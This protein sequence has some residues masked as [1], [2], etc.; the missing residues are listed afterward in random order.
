MVSD[1]NLDSVLV[2][3]SNTSFVN[4]LEKM[5]INKVS[6]QNDSSVLNISKVVDLESVYQTYANRSD[7]E[8]LRNNIVS[9][10]GDLSENL[11]ILV[12]FNDKFISDTQSIE[13]RAFRTILDVLVDQTSF[14]NIVNIISEIGLEGD[15]KN[16]FRALQYAAAINIAQAYALRL[17][18]YDVNINNI[19]IPE[20]FASGDYSEKLGLSNSSL[21][22]FLLSSKANNIT[23]QTLSLSHRILR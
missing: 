9:Q 1:N 15:A 14:K 13:L 17:G 7:T 20:D 3:T 23:G 10:I 8:N 2:K 5:F 19:C 16:Y 18:S 22:K 21:T 4:Y 11:I 12:D 6:H